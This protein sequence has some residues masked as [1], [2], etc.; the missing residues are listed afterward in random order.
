MPISNLSA[1][2]L[3]IWLLSAGAHG[4]ELLYFF[5]PSCG[6]CKAF[7]EEVAGIY[8]KTEAGRKAPLKRVEVDPDSFK[9]LESDVAFDPGTVPVFVLVEDGREIARLNGYG[10]DELFWMSMQR[11]LDQ[12][13]E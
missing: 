10:G 1:W 4:A 9:P 11:M 6:Y 12:L 2:A 3:C 5:S 8:P 7:D 13:P